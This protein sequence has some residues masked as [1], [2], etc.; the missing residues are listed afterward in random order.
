MKIHPA[1]R[2]F[3]ISAGIAGL[4][5]VL[6]GFFVVTK[7]VVYF[8]IA[9]ILA[10]ALS[11]LIN[12]LESHGI[13][14]SWASASVVLLSGA[15]LVLL[16]RTLM[17]I[18]WVQFFRLAQEIDLTTIERLAQLIEKEAA[19]YFSFIPPGFFT[20]N[21]TMLYQ[22]LFDGPA[23]GS[24]MNNMLA[25]FT[26]IFYGVLVIPVSVFFLLRDGAQLERSLLRLVPNAYF[27]TTLALVSKVENSL[28]RY[29]KGVLLQSLIVATLTS[30]LLSLAGLKNA[31]SVGLFIGVANIV[32]YFGPLLGDIVAITVA[33]AET[34]DVSLLGPVLLAVLITKAVD[35]VILQPLIFSRSAQM[36]P[37][38][39]LLVVLIAAEAGGLLAMIAAVPVTT[40]L[41]LTLEQIL[42]TFRNYRVFRNYA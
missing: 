27:E 33:L 17:P 37:I 11:P 12:R 6:A 16:S 42:W 26:N 30:V 39:I 10:Y 28:G 36:H 1:E 15:F 34:G 32:P 22:Q 7:I 3:K 19:G 29:M 5:A 25:V 14:R 38:V 18:L 2:I 24:V 13:P 41:K 8:V 40:I 21:L 31:L 9:L 23:L 20:K 35:N 4:I